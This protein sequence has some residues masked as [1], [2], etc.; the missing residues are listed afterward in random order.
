MSTWRFEA[1][2]EG[3]REG[4]GNT[5][6]DG[7]LAHDTLHDSVPWPLEAFRVWIVVQIDLEALHLAVVGLHKDIPLKSERVSAEFALQIFSPTAQHTR[8]GRLH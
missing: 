5:Q 7:A 2:L 3:R 6:E 1:T 8:E 4:V